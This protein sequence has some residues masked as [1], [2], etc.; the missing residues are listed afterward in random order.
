M[1]RRRRRNK[2]KH[3]DSNNKNDNSAIDN[4]KN[5]ERNNEKK[6]T[7]ANAKKSGKNT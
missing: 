5:I 2:N 3:I 7:T 6:A 4:D 1:T